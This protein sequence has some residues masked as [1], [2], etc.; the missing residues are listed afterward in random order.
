[1]NIISLG[2]GV[3]SSTMSLMAA[4]GEITPMPDCAIFADT[5]W[6]PKA[7]YEWLDWLEKQLPFPVY[8]VTKG[9]LRQAA[10][11][12]VNTTGG[13]YAAIPWFIMTA[14]GRG[15]GR[16]QCTYEYKILPIYRKVTELCG[17]KAGACRLWI[18]ISIDEAARMKPAKVKYIK[19]VWPL[20]EKGISR[21]D[22]LRWMQRHAFPQPPR[23][24]CIGCPFH[25]ANSLDAIRD[26]PDRPLRR[27]DDRLFGRGESMKCAICSVDY[28]PTSYDPPDPG[29][30]CRCG[31]KAIDL[32]DDGWSGVIKHYR[33]R[34]GDFVINVGCSI[35]PNSE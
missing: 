25:N 26:I 14:K 6:E 7:V 13:R 19:N 27:L 20:V 17:H 33:Y 8:R 1:M 32:W 16:R 23:S 2:A 12:K 35:L 29:E 24:S 18:G 34:I 22:C 31:I 11:E 9:N 28:W 5:Q 10:L 30:P 15:I 4:H 3:Q 21:N